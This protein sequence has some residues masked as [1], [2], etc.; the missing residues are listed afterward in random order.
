MSDRTEMVFGKLAGVIG[1]TA[2][3]TLKQSYLNYVADRKA[4]AALTEAKKAQLAA[5]L[6]KA[7]EYVQE[8]HQKTGLPGQAPEVKIGDVNSYIP[9]KHVIL[10][11]QKST[12]L[13]S[14]AELYTVMAH[15]VGHSQP[16]QRKYFAHKTSME[17][18]A[19]MFAVTSA[20]SGIAAS[21]AT[22]SPSLALAGVAVAGAGMYYAYQKG[23]GKLS[24]HAEMESDA[25]R[26]AVEQA[27]VN[28]VTLMMAYEKDCMIAM[29]SAEVSNVAKKFIRE[30]SVRDKAYLTEAVQQVLQTGRY[31]S[32]LE[33]SEMS[34]GETVS[35][36]KPEQQQVD[37]SS[38]RA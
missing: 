32:E 26:F 29:E 14:N 35:V 18:K 7:Q 21:S 37:I 5:V 11:D 24:R 17:L 22:Q 31:K 3:D 28:P 13:M 20:L 19:T 6:L 25:D 10:I 36:I 1:Q 8:I 12:L 38:G 27:G 34:L 2:A 30:Q 9:T 16:H 23:D 15:E 33:A 4:Q